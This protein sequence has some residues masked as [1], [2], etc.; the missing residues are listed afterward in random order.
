MDHWTSTTS[1]HGGW[2]HYKG[3]STKVK[4]TWCGD[5]GCTTRDVRDRFGM[6]T[7]PGCSRHI[8]YAEA[9]FIT[10]MLVFSLAM[11]FIN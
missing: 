5:H 10:V 4:C 7:I 2:P 8:L 1:F 11:C 3:Y 9:I 6:Y